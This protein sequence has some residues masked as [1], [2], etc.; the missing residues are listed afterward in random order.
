MPPTQHYHA[1]ECEGAEAAAC[2]SGTAVTVRER[3]RWRHPGRAP[4]ERYPSHPRRRSPACHNCAAGAQRTDHITRDDDAR[5]SNAWPSR[6]CTTHAPRGSRERDS[7]L[8]TKLFGNNGSGGTGDASPVAGS[9]LWNADVTW[10]RDRRQYTKTIGAAGR[11][12]DGGASGLGSRERGLPVERPG[13]ALQALQASHGRTPH[14]ASSKKR[15][16]AGEGQNGADAHA[17]SA[18]MRTGSQGRRTRRKTIPISDGRRWERRSTPL[19]RRATPAASGSR[20]D[21]RAP[22]AAARSGSARRRCSHPRCSAAPRAPA[23]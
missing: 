17:A 20:R 12:R 3:N 23:W 21:D 2:S 4:S 16:P 15:S 8:V 10:M 5:R 1:S 18:C 6:S 19:R 22:P 11:T 9:R 14:E 13:A 7:G